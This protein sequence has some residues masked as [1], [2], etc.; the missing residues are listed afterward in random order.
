MYCTIVNSS[1]DIMPD[2]VAE[3]RN[4]L[5]GALKVDSIASRLAQLHAA[6]I[7]A[8]G[9]D[10]QAL[11]VLLEGGAK[12]AND[13]DLPN[14]VGEVLAQHFLGVFGRY[15]LIDVPDIVHQKLQIVA[16][17]MKSTQSQAK[18]HGDV[19]GPLIKRTADAS[20]MLLIRDAGDPKARL[21]QQ[22]C[23]DVGI[24]LSLEDASVAAQRDAVTTT[25]AQ[26]TEIR[27]SVAAAAE[28]RSGTADAAGRHRNNPDATTTVLTASAA[29]QATE[30]GEGE[31]L[32][33][34]TSCSVSYKFARLFAV[35]ESQE[36]LLDFLRACISCRLRKVFIRTTAS[37]KLTPVAWRS[38]VLEVV[39]AAQLVK[40]LV[41]PAQPAP[42]IVA[43]VDELNTAPTPVLA[44]VKECFVD[45]SFEG[46]ALPSNIFWYEQPS[47]VDLPAHYRVPR[48]Q[49]GRH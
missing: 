27:S 7:E 32:I 34:Y 28:D 41:R 15:P 35:F 12:W 13:V 42:Q 4:A 24:S 46:E 26:R 9:D 22:W 37:D 20:K 43:F 23:V 8:A 36:Q 30:S 40:S 48:R 3:L 18:A 25:T 5:L 47:C 16:S 21:R 38:F 11:L 49:V 39:Q 31:R 6:E 45:H 10:P 2:M 19:G 14:R 1:S 44:A 29:L 33:L 17:N